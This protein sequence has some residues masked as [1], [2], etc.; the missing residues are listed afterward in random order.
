MFADLWVSAVECELVE[1]S[2]Q[3]HVTVANFFK[4]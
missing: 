2:Y 4:I 1:E 3:N